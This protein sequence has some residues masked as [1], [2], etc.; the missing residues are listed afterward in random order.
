M[1]NSIYGEDIAVLK[2]QMKDVKD[3]LIRIETKLD[4]GAATYAT[5]QELR[6]FKWVTVPSVALTTAILTALV[7]FFFTHQDP[8]ANNPTTSTTTTVNNPAG[9]TST[10]STKDGTPS[11]SSTA[12]AHSDSATPTDSQTSNGGVQVTPPKV[13]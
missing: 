2:D 3:A 5:K 7:V 8:N 4:G 9:S 12:S 6:S 1:A 13:P 11:T 10:T